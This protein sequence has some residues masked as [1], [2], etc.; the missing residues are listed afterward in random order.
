MPTN[1]MTE[2]EN[3][4]WQP[5]SISRRDRIAESV[6]SIIVKDALENDG[7]YA[8]VAEGLNLDVSTLVAK[9]AYRYAD[10]LIAEGNK[11]PRTICPTS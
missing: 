10:A 4:A 9:S 6:L 5:P 3:R 1:G 7:V 11:L 8:A 2:I